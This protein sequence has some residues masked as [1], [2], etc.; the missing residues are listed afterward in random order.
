MFTRFHDIIAF[1]NFDINFERLMIIYFTTSYWRCWNDQK[2]LWEQTTNKIHKC[3]MNWQDNVDETFT[4]SN[5]YV[6]IRYC[7]R[8][9]DIDSQRLTQTCNL[10]TIINVERIKSIMYLNNRFDVISTYLL[11]VSFNNLWER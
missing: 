11:R 1:V 7:A 3:E 5:S 10:S 6:R 4:F 9:Y 2:I 8:F